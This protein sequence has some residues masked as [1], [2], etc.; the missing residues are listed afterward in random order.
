[1]LL[2]VLFLWPAVAQDSRGT[3]VPPI[4]SIIEQMERVQFGHPPRLPYQMVREYRLFGAKSSV[5]D[6]HVTAETSG[7]QRTR[8]TR[9]RMR[10]EAS[11]ASKSSGASSTTKYKQPLMGAKLEPRSLAKTTIPPTL[12]KYCSMGFPNHSVSRCYSRESFD[13]SDQ[14]EI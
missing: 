13:L 7:H 3:G 6:S 8:P 5:S 10:R 12:G 11:E 9:S 1:M 2:S 4:V 14:T